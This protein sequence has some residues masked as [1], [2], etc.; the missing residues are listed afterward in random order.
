MDL[1]RLKTIQATCELCSLY[2]TRQRPVFERRSGIWKENGP[3]EVMICGMCPGPEENK[4]GIPFIGTAGKILDAILEETINDRSV[5]ITN[6]VKCFVTPG[7]S[8]EHEWMT[9]CL[10]YLLVQIS[11]LKP[12]VIIGLGKDVCNYLLNTDAAIGKLRGNVYNYMGTKLICTYH[13]SY[14]ARGGGVNHRD[15]AKVLE[16]FKK[17][18]SLL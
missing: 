18:V 14:L 10:P 5:Y 9:T 7:K 11:L 15:F 2:K 12:K 6:L 4:Y 17:A 3:A 13:P 8:L 16:D 1:E